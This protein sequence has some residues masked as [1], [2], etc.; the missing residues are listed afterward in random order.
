MPE[1]DIPS[2]ASNEV[3]PL[4]EAVGRDDGATIQRLIREGQ[5]VNTCDDQGRTLLHYA[6][7]TAL[8]RISAL[9]LALGADADSQDANGKRPFDPANI[10]QQ[11][12]HRVRQVY[13]RLKTHSFEQVEDIPSPLLKIA[14]RLEQDGIARVTGLFAAE[15]LGRMHNDAGRFI[16]DIEALLSQGKGI[17]QHYDEELHWCPN[18]K[19]FICNNAFKYSPDLIEFCFN[20]A[21]QTIVN[22]YLGQPS[23]VSRGVI[24]RYPSSQS[25]NQRAFNWHHDMEDKRL[26]IMVLLTDIGPDDQY[27]SYVAGS[28]RLFHP[29]EM[30]QQNSYPLD[31]CKTHLDEVRVVNSTGKAGDVFLFDSNGSHRA[32]RKPEGALRDAFFVEFATNQSQVWGGDINAALIERL[33]QNGTNPFHRMQT[34][35]KKWGQPATRKTPGW[36]DTL[37]RYDTWIN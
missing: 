2:F 7:K 6:A 4:F 18:D 17:K 12:L 26:K 3:P 35:E 30:F 23:F 34:A 36:V 15:A 14:D 22:L 10:S 33:S 21:L 16:V 5:S 37:H 27:M 19:A 20:P 11:K 9:L 24:V 25:S 28:H 8:P 13:Q 31:Y 29:L 32:V 1:T